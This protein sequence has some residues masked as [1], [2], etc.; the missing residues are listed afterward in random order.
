MS[1]RNPSDQDIGLLYEHWERM[2]APFVAKCRDVDLFVTDQFPVWKKDVNEI[3]FAYHNGQ[4]KALVDH[5]TN[6]Q[7]AYAPRVHRQPVG[8]GTAHKDAADKAENFGRALLMSAA[9]RGTTPL[10]KAGYGNLFTYGRTV[11]YVGA[12][13]FQEPEPTRADGE[14][15]D[16]LTERHE[17]WE[18]AQYH[19]NPIDLRTL[20][21]ARVLMD[22]TEKAPPVAMHRYKAYGYAL[23]DL[24][25]TKEV[26][27][28]ETGR[29]VKRFRV[30][31]GE[32]YRLH[33][34]V[35]YW[36]DLWHKLLVEE[37]VVIAEPNTWGF[38]PLTQCFSGKGREL[39][40]DEGFAPEHLAMGFIETLTDLLLMEA[41]QM[42]ARHYMLMRQAHSTLW[43]S[44]AVD[45]F[46]VAQQMNTG[47]LTG[48]EDGKT[49]GYLAQPNVPEAL[50]R[51]TAQIEKFKQ[52]ASFSGLTYGVK[53]TGVDTVGQT[54]MLSD[55]ADNAFNDVRAQ[56]KDAT[57]ILMSRVYQLVDILDQPIIISGRRVVKA[58]LGHDYNAEVDFEL[59]DPQLLLQEKQAALQE[60]ESGLI[61]MATY[62]RIARYEDSSKIRMGL[63]DDATDKDPRV[64]AEVSAQAFERKGFREIGDQVRAEE[65][66]QR[67]LP[68]P[69]DG[70]NL[71]ERVASVEPNPG[72]GPA[73]QAGNPAV[74]ARQMQDLRK[75]LTARTGK[76][77]PRMGR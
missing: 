3:R 33:N 29:K 20:H 2:F 61:D 41:Q 37:E 56:M 55:T 53:P 60:Y 19:W 8:E 76:P 51:D 66:A 77:R 36:S 71:V 52:D 39:T 10:F 27:A 40:D 48:V 38:Q 22:P 68:A 24:T 43:T 70:G 75:P 62:H 16:E 26:D 11:S 15:S 50:F 44:N 49:V 73:A 5:A 58:D 46:Q 18:R 45:P 9:A 67:L 64:I 17:R 65:A 21:P 47:I 35:I 13:I 34:V 72:A 54:A 28:K 12:K 63:I 1:D 7:A 69:S 42:N 74:A 31:K 57:G 25:L 30:A 14:S 4:A 6:A 23:R 32:D 59:V